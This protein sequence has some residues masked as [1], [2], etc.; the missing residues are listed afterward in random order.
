MTGPS[1]T[2]PVLI[3]GGAGF[4]GSNLAER[5]LS[6]GTPVLI[7][8]NLSRKGTERNLRDLCDTYGD[9]V[10]PHANDVRDRRV[11]EELIARSRSVFHF[12]AQV[13]V[14]TSLADPVED[15]ESNLVGTLNVLEAI[16]KQS[17]A[18]P[19]LFTSTN[20][21][22]GNLHDIELARSHDRYVP[23]DY[24]TQMHGI[25]ESRPLDFHS[26]Y[27]CSKGAADQYVLDYA[28]MYGLPAT[29]FRMSCIYGRRQ[30]GTEDQ[31]W[32]AH[33]ALRILRDQGL[34]IYGDGRQVRD[35]LYVDD[36]IDAMLL[37]MDDIDLTA[38]KA[39]NIGG[40]P[41]NAV[42]LLEVIRH[43][44]E[45]SQAEPEIRY[46]VWRKGDQPY[47]VSDTRRFTETTGWTPQIPVEQ[48]I[49]QL[50]HWLLDGVRPDVSRVRE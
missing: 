46:D 33:F 29:V 40:G 24:E 32:V 47:Y 4:I 8:D 13:A 26:P 1:E 20:K 38:G 39:F 14:T 27:G 45:L 48:G 31:G 25:G 15:F 49:S 12:A 28:R 3:T 44:A 10:E 43:L 42:S 50:H 7:L 11:V 5:L 22:Y 18:P 21:V 36:L 23:L 34:T 35:I 17:P 41:E 37:A 19:L 9:L 2:R 30:L 16:R 6:G